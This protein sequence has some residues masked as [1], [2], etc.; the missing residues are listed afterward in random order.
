MGKHINSS[1]KTQSTLEP[2]YPNAYCPLGQIDRLELKLQFAVACHRD[3]ERCL[4]MAT[5]RGLPV[6]AVNLGRRQPFNR[7]ELLFG[8]RGLAPLE[9]GASSSGSPVVRLS[10]RAQPEKRFISGRLAFADRGSP[11]CG[12]TRTAPPG[13][14]GQPRR[15]QATQLQ[16]VVQNYEITGAAFAGLG[17]R[18]A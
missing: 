12:F 9:P 8:G 4:F 17:G 1:T 11:G 2:S 14:S 18:D 7:R 13:R 3:N 15:M 5:C 6:R 16:Y 10:F